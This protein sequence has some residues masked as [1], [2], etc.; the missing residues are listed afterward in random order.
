MRRRHVMSRPAG[1]WESDG[2]MGRAERL[3]V[4]VDVK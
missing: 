4:A 3:D 1:G 2:V